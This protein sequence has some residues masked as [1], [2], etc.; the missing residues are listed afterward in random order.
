MF[1]KILILEQPFDNRTGGGITLSNLFSGWDKEKLAVVAPCYLINQNTNF[2]V[3]SNYY[4]IGNLEYN[5]KFPFK[6][7]K[8]KYYSGPVNKQDF[9]TNETESNVNLSSLRVKLIDNLFYPL[10]G[11]LGLF[12]FFTNIELSSGL[13][14]W[15]DEYNPDIIYAQ[16]PS[17]HSVI[18]CQL[19][20]SYLKKPMI[21]HMMDDWPS[22]TEANG[23]LGEYWH[24]R[25][26]K[27]LRKLFEKTDMFFSIS[28]R[29]AD[30]Y[31][32]RYDKHFLTFLNPIEID[33][34]NKHRKADYNLNPN[35][36]IL[37]AGRV[38]TG[39][40]ES[41]KVIAKAVEMVNETTK[42][43]VRFALQTLEKPKWIDEFNYVK[44]NPLVEYNELPKVFAQADFLILPYDFNEKGLNYIKMSMPTKLPEYLASGTPVIVFAPESTAL[45]D[46]VRK[47]YCGYVVVNNDYSIL[48]DGIIKLIEDK[49]LREK[50]A[51]NGIEISAKNHNADIVRDNFQKTILS[52]YSQT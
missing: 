7:I 32:K 18:F 35:L 19:I 13:R 33:F 49:N 4:Q 42:L 37:Y 39:I 45:V 5:W 28:D 17:F 47:N 24:Q 36:T 11:Y 52:L 29:M 27:E 9:D 2:E 21:F 15:L 44:H 14:K 25:A 10:L 34:W 38:G 26:D 50:I 46:Y 20:Q 30:V 48:A 1:C 6:L 12:N 22:M 8:K 41:L 51:T 43:K 40:D 31:K 23:L 3:C 16:A